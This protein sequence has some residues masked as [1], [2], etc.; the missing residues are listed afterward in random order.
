M[1]RTGKG[2]SEMIRKAAENTGLE[3]DLDSIISSVPGIMS[4]TGR[5]DAAHTDFPDR[6][7]PDMENDEAAGMTASLERLAAYGM[8]HKYLPCILAQTDITPEETDSDL[9]ARITAKLYTQ[10]TARRFERM[11]LLTR[12]I[13]GDLK[14]GHMEK[15]LMEG[16]VLGRIPWSVAEE[17]SV[18]E[19]IVRDGN[20]RI[21]N[22]GKDIR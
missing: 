1:N 11:G 14:T 17:I 16:I 12:D 15:I 5:K 21:R 3:R 9:T 19:K 6:G 20:D 18:L 22:A 13:Y 10:Y 8:I 7:I 2:L 4:D